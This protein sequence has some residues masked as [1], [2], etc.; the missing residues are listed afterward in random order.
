MRRRQITRR[1]CLSLN[2]MSKKNHRANF[3]T[4]LAAAACDEYKILFDETPVAVVEGVWGQDFEVKNVNKSALKLFGAESIDEFHKGFN[5]VLKKISR[6]NLLEILSARLKSD[7]CE[8]ELKLSTFKRNSVYVF[9]RM[10]YIPAVLSNP[11]HVIL[12][13]HDITYQKRQENFLKKLSQIDGLTQIYNQRTIL[14]RAEEELMRAQRYNLD[15]SCIIFDLD[16]FKEVNDTLGHLIGDKCIKRA[17]VLLKQVLR[18]TDVIGRYGGDEF[19][20]ILPETKL[21]QA[22]VPV[23][24]FMEAYQQQSEIKYKNK[25]VKTTFSVGISA[26]PHKSAASSKDLI[27]MADKALYISKTSGGNQFNL[28]K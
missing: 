26:Y 28:Y 18:K 19:L 21:E 13:F 1:P 12:A 16:N 14:L 27:A 2:K 6:K 22:A 11:Q 7:V 24:R 15:L 10:A 17:A 9:M 25:S 3:A 5:A 8:I 20:V 23:K 4:K